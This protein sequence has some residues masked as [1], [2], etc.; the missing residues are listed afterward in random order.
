MIP[1]SVHWVESAWLSL[2]PKG[3]SILWQT[4]M[5]LL[6]SQRRGK[7]FAKLFKTVEI[8]QSKKKTRIPCDN[9]HALS[10]SKNVSGSDWLL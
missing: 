10:D 2:G 4:S 8:W 1:S 7:R 9:V 6:G 3:V 5:I